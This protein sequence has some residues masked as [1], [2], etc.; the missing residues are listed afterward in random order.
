MRKSLSLADKILA[1][2]ED[3]FMEL[4]KDYSNVEI[5]PSPIK[6]VPYSYSEK[7]NKLFN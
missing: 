3:T 1:I 6:E 2:N 5:V 4:L 7:N